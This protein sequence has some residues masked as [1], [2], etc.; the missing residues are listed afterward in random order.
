MI[1]ADIAHR[2]SAMCDV[3]RIVEISRAYKC[4][5]WLFAPAAFSEGSSERDGGRGQP[6]ELK[7]LPQNN[8]CSR[9]KWDVDL[10]PRLILAF[11]DNDRAPPDYNRV[12]D[13]G[14]RGTWEG[15][16]LQKS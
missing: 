8:G 15:G 2:H 14:G 9:R 10:S 7:I 1:L 16:E 6:G 13:A 11:T 3:R 12:I 5:V 4:G